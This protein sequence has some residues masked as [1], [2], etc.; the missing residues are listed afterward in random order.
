[1]VGLLVK[2]RHVQ[3]FKDRHGRTRYYY[4][5]EGWPRTALPD[6]SEPGFAAAY[7]AA[8][9]AE[10]K[11][12]AALAAPAGTIPAL[13]DA[14]LNSTDFLRNKASS[15]R[16]TRAILLRFVKITGPRK[17]EEMQRAHVMK[18]VAGMAETPAAANNMLKKVRALMGW[19][20][21]NGWRK[22]DPTAKVKKFKEGTHHTWTDDELAQFE[23]RWPLGSR[24]RTVYALALYTGQR[25][26]DI[27]TRTKRHY[28]AKAGT[29]WVV[30]GKTGTELEIPVHPALRAAIEAWNPRHLVLLATPDGRGTSIKALTTS[31]SRAIDKAGLPERCVLHGLRKAAARRLAEAGCSA[32]EIMAI[33]GHRSLEEVERYCA[34]AA[35][36]G[37]GRSAMDKLIENEKRIKL[38]NQNL[39]VLQIGGKTE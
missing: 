32:H 37:L 7:A 19:A 8:A 6:P 11:P 29:V 12:S 22:D 28:N 24:E 4:R 38:S 16:V 21:A 1:M 5:R 20:I 23:E 35:Q 14:Y 10:R 26:E 27:G 17:A 36:R 34:A 18:I 25:R 9:G 15:Q 2:M 3:R 39:K 13:V 31:M 30:Q 33:T